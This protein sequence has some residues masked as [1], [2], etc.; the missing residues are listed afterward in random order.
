MTVR[1]CATIRASLLFLTALLCLLSPPFLSVSLRLSQ[2]CLHAVDIVTYQHL[3]QQATLKGTVVATPS[4]DTLLLMTADSH[5]HPIDKQSVLQHTSDSAAFEYDDKDVLSRALQREFG[6]QFYIQS[7]AHYLIC[8]SA[9]AAHTNRCTAALERLFKGFFAY[10]KNRGLPLTHSPNRLVI[11]LH[12]NREIYQQHAQNELGDAV[13]SVRGYYS[14]K[15]NR[16]NLLTID[17]APGNGI[18]RTNGVLAARTMAT[19]IHEATHQ[20]SYNSGLQTRLAP[21]PLWFSE[22]LAVFFEPPNLKTQAGYQPIGE[23]SPLHLATYRGASRVRKVMK[24]E[25]L[26]SHD[27]TF[28]NSAT[29]RLAYAQSWALTYFL[30]RTR[31]GEFLTYLKTQGAKQSLSADTPELR[32]R[33]FEEAFGGTM[34][35]LQREFQ[36][37]MQR[38]K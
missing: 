32:L 23:V 38:V 25:E 22:G 16:V 6:S 18:S 2:C 8:S 4:L 31:R 12:G 19:V 17:V 1:I 15:T 28:R 14:Q 3:G 26:V 20:L 11:V 7:S 9:P 34:R 27:R 33:D 35:E 13:S 21:H 24:L 29:I 10:W 30:I 36:R 5:Y 37:Y